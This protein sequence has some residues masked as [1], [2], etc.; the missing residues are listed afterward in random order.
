MDILTIH[1]ANTY[2]LLNQLNQ[3]SAIRRRPKAMVKRKQLGMKGPASEKYEEVDAVVAAALALAEESNPEACQSQFSS[4]SDAINRSF[5]LTSSFANNDSIVTKQN[6]E[7]YYNQRLNNLKYANENDELIDALMKYGN[8][9]KNW[10][11]LNCAIEAND[12]RAALVL[13]NFLEKSDV[14]DGGRSPLDRLHAKIVQNKAISDEQEQLLRKMTLL[15][16]QNSAQISSKS[17]IFYIAANY[18]ELNFIEWLLD[19]GVDLNDRDGYPFMGAIASGRVALVEYLISRGADLSRAKGALNG[20]VSSGSLELV[21]FLWEQKGQRP[22]TPWGNPLYSAI[23]HK[24][25]DI[26]EYLL[27]VGVSPNDYQ[28]VLPLALTL[29]E[30]TAQEKAYKKDV[31]EL[32]VKHGAKM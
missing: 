2:Q 18:G 25:F 15:N 13:I 4:T 3:A 6:I 27:Q 1:R 10:N 22:Y 26:L 32:L 30:S 19:R 17:L 24:N 8:N 5:M 28:K 9:P 7:T 16:F 21:K 20:A 23:L 29:S 14:M 12:F 11:P 31:I